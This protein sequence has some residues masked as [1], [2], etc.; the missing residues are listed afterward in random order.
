M[1]FLVIGLD[2]TDDSAK[3][4]RAAVREQHI[5]MGNELL[6]SGSMWYGAA[7]LDDDGNMKGS[8]LGAALRMQSVARVEKV[9]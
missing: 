5:A 2:G 9:A 8:T 6:K 1:Q 7:L 4:R 3:E